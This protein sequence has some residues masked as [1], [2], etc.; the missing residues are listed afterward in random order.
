MHISLAVCLCFY[1]MIH[2]V[3]N[4]LLCELFLLNCSESHKAA[5]I[6]EAD[7]IWLTFIMYNFDD[8]VYKRVINSKFQRRCIH[9]PCCWLH[10][11]ETV[12]NL[13][14]FTE[15]TLYR[16]NFVFQMHFVRRLLYFGCSHSIYKFTR[17]ISVNERTGKRNVGSLFN[18]R[19][20]CVSLK[21][22]TRVDAHILFFVHKRIYYN[23]YN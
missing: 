14:L 3:Y 10:L 4:I 18:D 8:I 11:H 21:S 2:C 7:K 12:G 16:Y 23:F 19:R 17:R 20:L 5:R 1:L 22:F 9:L 15:I 13:I 6:N